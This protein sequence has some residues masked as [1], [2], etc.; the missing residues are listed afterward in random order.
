MI[1]GVT[2]TNGS[3]KGEVAKYLVQKGFKYLSTREF[4]AKEVM[5]RGLAVDRDTLTSVSNEVRAEH[6]ATYFLEQM[7][8][9]AMPGEDVVIESV[10]EVPGAHL[11]HGRGGIIIGVDA[12][13][14][15][16]YERIVKR[17][18]ETDKVDYD[19]FFAQDQRE[20][21]STDPTKQNVMGVMALADFVLKNDGT[22]EEFHQKID[23]VLER[24]HS[25][26]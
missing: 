4:I 19:T 22:L 11:F 24:A 23:E 12:D 26:V 10:R 1:I 20:H 7:L 25:K 17:A 16:R 8:S 14:H 6:G 3:G 2:G 15:I 13:P 5:S 9:H 21:T 18:S